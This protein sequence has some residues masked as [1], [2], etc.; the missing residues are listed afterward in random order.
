MHSH[1]G[2]HVIGTLN[3]NL[4]YFIFKETFSGGVLHRVRDQVFSLIPT[5]YPRTWNSSPLREFR[6]GWLL[7]TQF[8]VTLIVVNIKSNFFFHNRNLKLSELVTHQ[9][10]ER[11]QKR[12]ECLLQQLA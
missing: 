9:W 11:L 8:M 1:F 3:Y 10:I 12:K 5:H 2:F 4:S 7:L 6:D